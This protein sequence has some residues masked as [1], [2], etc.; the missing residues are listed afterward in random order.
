M[1]DSDYRAMLSETEVALSAAMK[2][3]KGERVAKLEGLG[4][5]R[6]TDGSGLQVSRQPKQFF[7]RLVRQFLRKIA[8]QWFRR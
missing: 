1:K 2:E 6:V 8:G 7:P 4:M 5:I 3:R